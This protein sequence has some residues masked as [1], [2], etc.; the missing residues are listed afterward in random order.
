MT[1]LKQI[2]AH[3]NYS[4]V[5][6]NSFLRHHKHAPGRLRLLEQSNRDRKRLHTLNLVLTQH[7]QRLETRTSLHTQPIS[8]G[9]HEQLAVASH[10]YVPSTMPGP[11]QG[12][13]ARISQLGKRS[14]TVPSNTDSNNKEKGKSVSLFPL[15]STS[16]WPH[17][18]HSQYDP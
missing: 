11:V 6:I 9:P 4:I 16:P 3:Q 14:G 2:L 8:T 13:P 15:Y 5:C 7:Q 17:S 1:L 12:T 10:I 18:P